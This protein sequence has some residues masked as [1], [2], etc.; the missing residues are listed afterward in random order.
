MNRHPSTSL[1][2]L[3]IDDD[4]LVHEI[5]RVVAEHWKFSVCTAVSAEDALNCLDTF[6]PDVIVIDIFMHERNGFQTLELLR[7]YEYSANS[8]FVAMTSYYSSVVLSR[9]ILKGFDAFLEKPLD[10]PTLAD[11]LR[12]LAAS[13]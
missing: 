8:L 7:K 4:I 10:A 1:S 9:A 12:T 3:V 6:D 11:S 13:R 5:F 2:V